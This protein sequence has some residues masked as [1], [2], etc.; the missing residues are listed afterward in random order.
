MRTIRFAADQRRAGCRHET[1][2]AV[3][4]GIIVTA[5]LLAGVVGGQ[6]ANAKPQRHT[7]HVSACLARQRASIATLDRY[8]G[9][10]P[11]NGPAFMKQIM[12][13]ILDVIRTRCLPT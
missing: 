5:A 8:G 3:K 2:G 4:R 9:Y 11:P 7:A 12:N 6:A 1:E 13:P 10:L